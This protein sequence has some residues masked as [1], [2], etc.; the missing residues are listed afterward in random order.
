MDGETTP[1]PT[2][3]PNSIAETGVACLFAAYS[4]GGAPGGIDP[5]HTLDALADGSGRTVDTYLTRGL[6]PPYDFLLRVHADE[7]ADVQELVH[8]FDRTAL[9]ERS[10]LEESFIGVTRAEEYVPEMPDLADELDARTY[11]APAPRYAVVIPTRKS[12]E[13][14]TLA[15][16]ERIELMREHVERTLDYL[17]V[18]K[19]QLY[20]STGLD[21]VD[22]LTYFETGDP[23]SFHELVRKLQAIEEYR[24]TAYGDPT[25]VGTIRS[26]EDLRAALA[27]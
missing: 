5:A 10:T 19:R 4:Y 22:F 3:D 24:H 21:D 8:E 23:S 13:W 9:G 12:A 15:E 2:A 11:E 25:I 17:D 18:V 14:W 16:S 26:P 1:P 20:H 6:T 7:L 27:E